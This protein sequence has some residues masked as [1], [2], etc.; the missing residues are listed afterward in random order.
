[1]AARFRRLAADSNAAADPS[2]FPGPANATKTSSYPGSISG[3][4]FD[5][6]SERTFIQSTKSSSKYIASASDIF[7]Y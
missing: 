1:M 3:T 6:P 4:L 5:D 2:G 7:W